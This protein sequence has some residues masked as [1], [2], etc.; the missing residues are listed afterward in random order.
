MPPPAPSFVIRPDGIGPA[1]FGAEPDGVVDFVS[2]VLGPPSRDTG[3]IDPFEIGPCPGSEIRQVGWND[4]LLEF[5]DVSVVAEGR[6]HFYGYY[7]GD[8]SG[9]AGVQ[10]LATVDGLTIGSTVADLLAAHP[11]VSLFSGDEF[12]GPNFMINDALRGTLTGLADNDVILTFV[13]GLPCN[14]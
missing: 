7:Y 10:G 8:G 1:A 13:G 6:R 4:L 2:S 11:A 9:N 5:G 14:G 12:I 3:W